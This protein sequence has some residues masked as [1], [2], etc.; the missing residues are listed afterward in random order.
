VKAVAVT[1]ALAIALAAVVVG[2]L[3][4]FRATAATGWECG[5]SYRAAGQEVAEAVFCFNPET[6]RLR[7]GAFA[8]REGVTGLDQST[9]RTR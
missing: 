5:T 6:Q 1:A 8:T 2:G 4:G 9:R 7:I 3:V